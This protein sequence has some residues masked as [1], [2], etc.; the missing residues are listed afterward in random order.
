MRLK[1][2][3]LENSFPTP[4]VLSLRRIA[5]SSS[6]FHLGTMILPD[7]LF[8]AGRKDHCKEA[9]NKA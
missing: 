1:E 8:S 7:V 5:S 6:L 4:S 3:I 2:I 9:V